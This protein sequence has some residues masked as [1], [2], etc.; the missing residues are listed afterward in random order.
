[1]EAVGGVA[2]TI[3]LFEVALKLANVIRSVSDKIQEGPEELERWISQIESLRH[4]L[5]TMEKSPALADPANEPVIQ[6]CRGVCTNL[7]AIFDGLEV[8]SGDGLRKKT[9]K[10]IKGLDQE[11]AI[12]K[13]FEEL[14]RFK[15][16]LI[17]MIQV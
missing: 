1:M 7:L 14:E 12:R 4:V 3:Q 2:A 11:E 16:T 6:G 8:C 17:L 5:E 10:A 15:A 9:W 13:R